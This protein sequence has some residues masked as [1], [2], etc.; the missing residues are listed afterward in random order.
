MWILFLAGVLHAAP[1]PYQQLPDLL[2][3]NGEWRKSQSLIEAADARRGAL[4]R[5]FLPTLMARA[6][7]ESFTLGPGNARTQ[8]YATLEASVNVYN[9]GRDKFLDKAR[10]ASYAAGMADSD[11]VRRHVLSR[12]RDLWNAWR[13][14]HEAV[15]ILTDT[16]KVNE[17]HL[18]AAEKRVR[19]GLTTEADT[20]DF[21]QY[22][23]ELEQELAR[24]EE[25]V[26][27]HAKLLAAVL[28]LSER[29]S[30]P[31]SAT[32]VHDDGLLTVSFQ[33]ENHPKT[34]AVLAD[35]ET[36]KAN[37]L[38]SNRWWT[39]RVDVYGALTHYTDRQQ[40]FA[41]DSQREDMAVGAMVTVPLFDGGEA[42]RETRALEHTRR[43]EELYAA[44]L[45]REL[46][47]EHE[48]A[49]VHVKLTHNLLH[50]AAESKKL[51]ERY[52][53]VTLAEYQ[54][55]VKNSPDVREANE[56]LANAR[57]G[58]AQ[59]QWD[60]ETARA[61]LMGLLGK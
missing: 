57:L 26:D 47:A 36:L 42:R 16:L 13:H 11:D 45:K 25:E 1:L 61:N 2:T 21:R 44:Q 24:E 15:K 59:T 35:A 60:H 46:A 17:G 39:P 48:K 54:R 8:N 38:R 7:R 29:P 51:A 28:G 58:E 43:G 10:E 40:F 50:K 12:T 20:L 3:T 19:A 27:D 34:R 55:G 53:T 32:H 18:R 49:I 37:S 41:N 22:A 33:P 23:L 14:H 52:M 56:R 5:S 4:K 31:E 9:G 30:L 6:G